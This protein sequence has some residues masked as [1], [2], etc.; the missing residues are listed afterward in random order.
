MEDALKQLI[1]ALSNWQ[2]AGIIGVAIAAVYL[3]TKLTKLAPV[4]R[5]IGSKKW[6]RPVV[7]ATLAGLGALLV[8]LQAG[9]PIGAALAAFLSGALSAGLGAVGWDSSVSSAASSLTAVGRENAAI[10][11]GVREVI[12]AGDAKAASVAGEA[13]GALDVAAALPP[14]PARRSALADF[15][16]K[17]L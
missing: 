15:G 6:L 13:K 11:A 16:R 8:A 9:Q 17:Y 14:G 4:A 10:S 1:E 2:T 3:L 12:V 5:L 7:A